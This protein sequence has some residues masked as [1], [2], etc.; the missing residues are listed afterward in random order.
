MKHRIDFSNKGTFHKHLFTKPNIHKAV[1]STLKEEGIREACEISVLLC[2]D[3]EIRRINSSFRSVDKSTDVLSFPENE[4]IPGSFS[5]ENCDVNCDSG[6]I[7]LGD[8]VL[9]IPHCENQAKEYGHSFYRE[10][11]YLTVHS[12]LHLLGYDHMDDGDMKK[13]MRDREK[14]IMGEEQ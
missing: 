10:I 3:E 4:L 6:R 12:V 14:L 7:I 5:A 8:I 11:R 13:M 1:F 9:S 2:D